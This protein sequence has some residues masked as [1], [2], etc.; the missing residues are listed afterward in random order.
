[1]DRTIERILALLKPEQRSAWQELVGP[2]FEYDLQ[3]RL[4]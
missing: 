3:W 1:M 4:D 2:P